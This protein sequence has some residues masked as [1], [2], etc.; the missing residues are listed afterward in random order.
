MT[1]FA[2]KDF[3]TLPYWRVS[4]RPSVYRGDRIATVNECLDVLEAISVRCRWL[5]LSIRQ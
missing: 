4:M 2:L 5:A 1:D 3:A